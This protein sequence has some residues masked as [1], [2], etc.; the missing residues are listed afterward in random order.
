MPFP[1][2][3]PR[4]REAGSRARGDARL[5]PLCPEGSV[6]PVTAATFGFLI[7]ARLRFVS[8]INKEMVGFDVRSG[9]GVAA[10]QIPDAIKT[11]L[12][13]YSYFS[14]WIFLLSRGDKTVHFDLFWLRLQTSFMLLWFFCQRKTKKPKNEWHSGDDVGSGSWMNMLI[15]AFSWLGSRAGSTNGPNGGLLR[16]AATS[17]SFISDRS[18]LSPPRRPRICPSKLWRSRGGWR[19][20]REDDGK[21]ETE[22]ERRRSEELWGSGGAR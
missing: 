16:F 13:F 7:L 1:P 2:A 14:K 11:V 3:P 5:V 21:K 10:V 20:A 4:W 22:P 17:S 8:V 19:R 18:A 12:K 15:P 6:C 9:G